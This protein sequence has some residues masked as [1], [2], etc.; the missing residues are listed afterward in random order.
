MA[1][2]L[3]EGQQDLPAQHVEVA[4][5]RGAVDHDPVAVIELAHLEVLSERLGGTGC[6]W[7]VAH[8][9]PP[10]LASRAQQG[11]SLSW[12]RAGGT[13]GVGIR[14]IIAHLQEPLGPR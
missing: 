9:G 10:A 12:G 7:E 6:G 8:C 4:G 1:H 13:H 14:V 3:A 2:R 11:T 5:R